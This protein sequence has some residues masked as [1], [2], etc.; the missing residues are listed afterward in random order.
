MTKD[1][2]NHLHVLTEVKIFFEEILHNIDYYLGNCTNISSID[3]KCTCDD[4]YKGKNCEI[5]VDLCNNVTCQNNGVCFQTYLNYTC[6][7]LSGYK[8]LHCEIAET[9]GIIRTYVAKSFGYIAI[10]MLC[11]LIGFLVILDALKYIFGIDPA[12]SQ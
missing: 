1:Y 8:G 5:T 11:G 7:C 4:G 3:F 12:K 9:S 6:Q 2:V 10:L